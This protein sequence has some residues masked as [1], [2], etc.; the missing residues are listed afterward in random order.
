MQGNSAQVNAD[1]ACIG[2]ASN[3]IHSY[4]DDFRV[5]TEL[6]GGISES[7][8]PCLTAPLAAIKDKAEMKRRFTEATVGYDKIQL[9]HIFKEVHGSAKG[10]QDSMLHKFVSESFWRPKPV[11]KSVC[12]DVVLIMV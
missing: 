3:A 7:K 1:N 8:L 4:L 2:T 5:C 10:E 9:F 11:T 12:V 6:G